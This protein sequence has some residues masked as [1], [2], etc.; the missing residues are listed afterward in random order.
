MDKESSVPGLPPSPDEAI[1]LDDEAAQGDDTQPDVGKEFPPEVPGLQ[2]FPLSRRGENQAED[3]VLPDAVLD[4][5]LVVP[6]NVVQALSVRPHMD[7][8]DAV[9]DKLAAVPLIEDHVA[10]FKGPV[11]RFEGDRVTQMDQKGGHAVAG[12]QEIHGLALPHQLPQH[13]YIFD[14]I[15]LSHKASYR[16]PGRNIL[17]P[18]STKNAITIPFGAPQCKNHSRRKPCRS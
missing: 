1:S 8:D 10:G 18:G 4:L 14:S 3:L 5:G 13:G 7:A 6:A 2:L 16:A 17:P 11:R 9:H 15:D 12:D